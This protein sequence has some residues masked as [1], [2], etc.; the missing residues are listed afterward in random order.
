MAHKLTGMSPSREEEGPSE[1]RDE[2]CEERLIG[3]VRGTLLRPRQRRT[4]AEAEVWD[5]GTQEVERHVG[6]P[7][8][9]PTLRAE[10]DRD[11]T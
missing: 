9:G 8:T 5:A 2:L 10:G 4:T 11:V 6:N 3:E 7:P 1:T